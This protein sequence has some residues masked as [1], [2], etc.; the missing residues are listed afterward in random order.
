MDRG[1]IV[2]RIWDDEHIVEFECTVDTGVFCGT[3][4]CYTGHGALAMFADDLRRFVRAFEGTALF[5]AGL[6]DGTKAVT[7][8][9]RAVDHAKHTV[10][11]VRLVTERGFRPDDVAR[12][13]VQFPIEAAGIDTFLRELGDIH[14]RGDYAF[15]RAA[16]Q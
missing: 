13:E 1:V 3:A 9:I 12:L 4:T 2:K 7:I 15:L 11:T 6:A 16:R 10:A 5:N 8:D 14:G